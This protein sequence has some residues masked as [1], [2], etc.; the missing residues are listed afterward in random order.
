MK[1]NIGMCLIM[2]SYLEAQPAPSPQAV[3]S[4]PTLAIYLVADQIPRDLLVD[5]TASPAG[6]SLKT[7]PI[8]SDADFVA[9]DTTNHTF[10]I[11]PAAAK[12]LVG[13]CTF[14][15]VPF[16]LVSEREPVY[17]GLFGTANSSQS[18]SVPVILTDLVEV[19]CFMGIANVPTEV[20]H[21]IG[22][23]DPG[24]TDQLMVLTNATTNVT[25]RIDRGYPPPDGFALAPDRRG[26]KRIGPAVEKLFGKKREP[27]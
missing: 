27:L 21:M 26:D 2:V 25:L 7:P 19:D 5:G 6:L 11:T 12:R 24:V 23:G 9:W 4:T 17:V 16:V 20:W 8:L 10:V 18:A 3:H 15:E 22:R 14:R 13:S 1:T